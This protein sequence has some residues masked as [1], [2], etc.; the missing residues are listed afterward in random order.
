MSLIFAISGVAPEPSP[1]TWTPETLQAIATALGAIATGI[2]AL[3]AAGVA[4][5]RF[6]VEQ[7]EK[8][9]TLE[10]EERE[11]DR[12]AAAAAEI[13]AAKYQQLRAEVR[14]RLSYTD[15]W[16]EALAEYGIE[17]TDEDRAARE[18]PP[19]DRT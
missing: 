1:W 17:E 5:R 14:A 6:S 16:D 19:V 10:R 11:K 12:E 13:A 15:G 18:Q 2:A 8:D 9:R 4:A 7:R 3:W